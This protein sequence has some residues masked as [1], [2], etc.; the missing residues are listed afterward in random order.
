M[1]ALEHDLEQLVDG[2]YRCR[3]CWWQ[4]PA[5][6]VTECP[7]FARL[8]AWSDVPP[9][10][11]SRSML[12]RWGLRPDSDPVGL[13]MVSDQG[14][15]WL[16]ELDKA[17]MPRSRTPAQIEALADYRTMKAIGLHGTRDMQGEDPHDSD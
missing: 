11:A 14:A 9:E 10:W 5:V 3:V 1:T 8:R 2:A 17:R 4:W 12:R 6:P 15:V 7:G 16:Y 13:L